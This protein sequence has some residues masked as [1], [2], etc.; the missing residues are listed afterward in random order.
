MEYPFSPE[1]LDALPEPIADIYRN[2][3]LTLLEEIADELVSLSESDIQKI[4]ALRAHRIPL[5]QIVKAIAK[6]TE[7]SERAI[8]RMLKEAAA[9]NE[10]YYHEAMTVAQLTAPE[11]IVNKQIVNAI[12]EQTANEIGNI[13]RSMGFWTGNR[14][15]PASQAFNW[16][17]D[18]AIV[19]VD[20][21]GISYSE[22]I[23]RA[24][25]S[26][27][28]GGLSVVQYPSGHRDAVDVAVRRAVLTGVGQLNQKYTDQSMDLLKTDL[29]EVSAHRGARNI[30]KGFRNHES[31]QGKIYRW[32]AYPRT[33]KGNYLDFVTTCGLGEVQGIYGANCR[34]SYHPFCEGVNRPAY[35]QEDLDK[36]KATK[37]TYQG[38][39]YDTYTATQQQRKIERTIRK[40]KARLAGAT[41]EADKQA[42]RAK[43]RRLYQEYTDFSNAAG[44]REQ[45]ERANWTPPNEG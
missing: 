23:A 44:L 6:A 12:I 29:V 39:E 45:R 40:E 16:A 36:L 4:R 10:L 13:S 42:S 18:N 25:R 2:L 3:E 38:K 1:W 21:G 11:Y 31:W 15:T 43:I 14:L 7:K 35:T 41:N 9:Q 24:T 26:L 8:Y 20:S 34:H 27:A 33:S 30:G 17:V 22:A 32:S 28:D 5:K 37:F 19:Q